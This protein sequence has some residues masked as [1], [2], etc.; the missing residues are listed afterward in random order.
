MRHRRLAGL[1]ACILFTGS[2]GVSA[3]DSLRVGNRVLVVGDSAAT[4]TALLGKPTHKS[5]SS[6]A[7][8]SGRGSKRGR[9][10]RGNTAHGEQWQYRRRGRVIVVTL[11]AGRVSDID[12][13]S[14]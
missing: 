6:A 11:V 1:L 3:S 8:G 13:R 12:D 4:V 2:A 14:S 9:T 5:H 7:R 10:A